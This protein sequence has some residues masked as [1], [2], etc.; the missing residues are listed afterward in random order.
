MFRLLR[1][2][3]PKIEIPNNFLNNL[4]ITKISII[5]S[6]QMEF[7]KGWN[8]FANKISSRNEELSRSKL[9]FRNDRKNYKKNLQRKV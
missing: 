8:W 9:L 6:T 5:Y 2:L 3:F 7:E 4:A 1:N